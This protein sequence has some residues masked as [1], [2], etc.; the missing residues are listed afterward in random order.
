MPQL[1]ETI[2]GKRLLE[3]QLPTLLKQL[4][5]IGAELERANDL[6][7]EVTKRDTLKQIANDLETFEPALARL[8]REY[9]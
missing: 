2:Y 7:E 8:L 9:L 1:H 3:H 4:E 5:K 6:K